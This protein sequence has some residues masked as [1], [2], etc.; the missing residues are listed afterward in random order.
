MKL[1]YKKGFT[2]I[3]LLVVVAIIGILASI[4]LVSLNS[5]R[6]KGRDASAKGSMSSLR[7]AAELY[8]DT[9][10]DYGVTDSDALGD[11]NDPA[12]AT[13]AAAASICEM[14]GVLL[15]AE[16][17]YRQVRSE[18]ICEV[19]QSAGQVSY[20]M[21]VVLNDQTTY[22]VDSNGY[23][24]SLDVGVTEPASPGVSCY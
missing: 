16:S 12:P 4:V 1:N 8:F 6:D 3:E 2:L 9:H 17:V 22:C 18:I 19:T 11:G 13:I 14:D 23:A 5:A 24:G 15:I 20:T 21:D 7:A 10:G